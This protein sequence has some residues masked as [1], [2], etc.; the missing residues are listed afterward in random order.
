MKLFTNAELALA[1]LL[2]EEPKHP[3]QLEKDVEQRDMRYWTDLSMSS[4]YKLL[5]KMEQEGLVAS[6]S[7]L[8]EENR[9]RKVY[10]LTKRGVSVM[11][12]SVRSALMTPDLQQHPVNVALYF[13]G[14]LT[15]EEKVACL[16]KYR[17]AIQQRMDCYKELERF[18]KKEN[19]TKE[20]I[21]IA[22]RLRELHKAEADW[23]KKFIATYT[24]TS[25]HT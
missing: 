7:C 10:S 18:M 17:D 2:A 25:P 4:I 24:D 5:K 12:E 6:S 13:M 3:Y 21:S 19:C 15:R 20:H 11:K 22:E 16:E 14:I 8:T 9:A 1:G 23:L